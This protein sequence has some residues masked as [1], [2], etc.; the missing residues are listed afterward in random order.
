MNA[1]EFRIS[2][3]TAEWATPMIEVID[4][5]DTVRLALADWE[6]DSPELLLGLTRL[7]MERHDAKARQMQ[8]EE[9]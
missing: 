9:D 5:A 3:T 1:F 2:N 7:V 6:I 4:T 8:I